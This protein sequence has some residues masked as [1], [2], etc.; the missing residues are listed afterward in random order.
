MAKN[1]KLTGVLESVDESTNGKKLK[2]HDI[3]KSLEKR[4]FGPLILA[5]ALLAALPTGVIPTIPTLAGLLIVF[6]SVQAVMGRDHPWVPKRLRDVSIK[7]DRFDDML[8][9]VKPYTKFVDRFI[10]PRMSWAINHITVR[11]VAAICILLALTLPPLELIPFAATIPATAIVFFAL[12]ISAR[13][14]LMILI[15]LTLTIG[16]A[17][18]V[19][20]FFL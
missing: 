13:D 6:I 12:G 11:A 8:D 7:K 2:F 14:G 9:R 20:L 16:G 17:I 19:P 3:V 4:G 10:H 18:A 1:N 5:P 15:G